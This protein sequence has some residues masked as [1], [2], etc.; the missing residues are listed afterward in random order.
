MNGSDLG[1][2]LSAVYW[3]QACD[4][5]GYLSITPP[6]EHVALVVLLSGAVVLV[7]CLSG[8]LLWP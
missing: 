5:Q 3:E 8:R 4:H 7:F 1:L 6:N 2:T